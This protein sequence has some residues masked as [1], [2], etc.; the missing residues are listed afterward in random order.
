MPKGSTCLN[1]SEIDDKSEYCRGCISRRKSR[2]GETALTPAFVAAISSTSSKL[3]E[4]SLRYGKIGPH[5]ETE[6]YDS[7]IARYAKP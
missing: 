3:V 1:T 6:L 4:R 7:L 5:P 2:Y